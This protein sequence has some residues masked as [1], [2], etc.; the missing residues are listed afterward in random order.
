MISLAH[1][2]RA[3]ETNTPVG[4]A[5]RLFDKL[6]KGLHIATLAYFAKERTLSLCSKAPRQTPKELHTV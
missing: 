6:P 5:P 3:K 4:N 2:C 1:F